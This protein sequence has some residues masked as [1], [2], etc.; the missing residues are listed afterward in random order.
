MSRESWNLAPLALAMRFLEAPGGRF[1]RVVL[2]MLC[3]TLGACDNASRPGPGG[4]I[5]FGSGSYL[6]KFSL[7]DGSSEVVAYV[8]DGTVTSVG[9]Y[10]DGELLLTVRRPVNAREV[11][12]VVRFD[13]ATR[14]YTN[15]FEANSAV[16]LRDGEITVFDDGF[17]LQ[18]TRIVDK[19]RRLTNIYP[20]D[21][22]EEIAITPVSDN[23]LFFQV[24]KDRD[25][26]VFRYD[27]AAETLEPLD[28][29]SKVCNL[30]GALWVSESQQ[31][32][33]HAPGQSR[34]ES[35]YHFVAPDG[36]LGALL[37]RPGKNAIRPVLY[38]PEQ[39]V[40]VITEARQGFFG[41]RKK[42][43]VWIHDLVSGDS[44]RLVKDQYLGDEVA[45]IP[46]K[47]ANPSFAGTSP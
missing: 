34:A 40:L 16:F 27:A 15:L 17:N 20:H 33:C 24:A 46:L 30:D 42:S 11:K 1:R 32:L 2:V 4:F 8:G 3:L 6:G 13:I 31:M 35:E 21:F 14:H 39:R 18:A 47:S 10:R 9:N 43:A 23:V 45:Y 28:E 37:P 25:S 12:M 36:Q 26:R 41:G 19:D 7:G 5:F 22:D 38:L 44:H 29:F